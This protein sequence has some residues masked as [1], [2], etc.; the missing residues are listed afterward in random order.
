MVKRLLNKRSH[1][2]VVFDRFCSGCSGVGES[3]RPWAPTLAGRYG[4][5]A[6]QATC[7][8]A[9]DPR[10]GMWTLT[11]AELGPTP[12]VRRHSDRWRQF[13]LQTSMTFAA[14]LN[15]APKGIKYVDVG[16]SGGVWGLGAG[17]L[18]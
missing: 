6:F 17:L 3:K 11:I 16:T 15:L 9:D 1:T 7:N 10:P 13:V 4:R 18:S 14:V 12:G 5:Q 8:L 2:S